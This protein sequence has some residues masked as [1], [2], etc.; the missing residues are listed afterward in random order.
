MGWRERVS[1]QG[2][3]LET[4]T[5]GVVELTAALL[6]ITVARHAE[7]YAD[8]TCAEHGDEIDRLTLD[9]TELVARG[10]GPAVDEYLPR[11]LVLAL[12]ARLETS[13]LRP[14]ICARTAAEV[15]DARYGLAFVDRFATRDAR[16]RVGDPFPVIPFPSPRLPETQRSELLATLSPMTGDPRNRTTWIERTRHLRLAPAGVDQ[17]R[18]RLV[19]A[20]PWLDAITAE[21]RFAAAVTNHGQIDREFRWRRYDVGCVPVFYQVEPCDQAEQRRRI[22]QMLDD[23]RQLAVSVLVFP[24]LCLTEAMLQELAAAGRFAELA[25]VIAGSYHTATTEP[26]PGINR[27]IVFAEG[28]PLAAHDKFSDFHY[29]EASDRPRV[30]E[31]LV[32]PDEFGFDVLISPHAAVIP[33]ICKDAMD[34]RIVNLLVELAPT[35][36][37]VP[38][39]SDDVADFELLAERLARDPQAF[40]V[41]ACAG[42]RTQA[43]VGRP[44]RKDPVISVGYDRPQVAVFG[45]SDRPP[46]HN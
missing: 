27:C 36:V 10:V 31:H 8:Y 20:D 17:L 11:A 24:E 46:G 7:T 39:M 43:I 14:G 22:E 30:H 41:V 23:A 45:L 2:C 4:S 26:E 28:W 3:D 19:W 42:P 21:T 40:T 9:L 44:K 33:L 13:S 12:C 35:L 1:A 6:R 16:L 18:V 32:R 25:L 15:L 29:A 34:T 38:A 37:V 5:I